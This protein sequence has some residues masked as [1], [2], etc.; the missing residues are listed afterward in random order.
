MT[1]QQAAS[2]LMR[3]PQPN[4]ATVGR[5]DSFFSIAISHHITV[6]Q[7][8]ALNPTVDPATLQPGD[9]LRLPDTL[10]PVTVTITPER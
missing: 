7:I 8:K 10:A 2:D 9:Q 4:I 1:A 5:G 3:P 6:R